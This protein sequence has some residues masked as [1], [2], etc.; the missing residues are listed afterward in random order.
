MNYFNIYIDHTL[1]LNVWPITKKCIDH[2]LLHK[3]SILI[4]NKYL[5]KDNSKFFYWINVQN[6]KINCQL[7]YQ[8]NIWKYILRNS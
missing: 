1:V 4:D 7:K 8:N 3:K 5:K 2:E 6:K